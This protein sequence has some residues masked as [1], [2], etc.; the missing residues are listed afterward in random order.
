VALPPSRFVEELPGGVPALYRRALA[1]ADPELAAAVGRA[2]LDGKLR[3]FA[4]APGFLRRAWGPGWA[5]V[6]DA[7]YFKDP[8]TAHGMTDALRDAELLAR[9]IVAGT[10]EALAGYQAVRDEVSMG[11]F[12]ATDRIASFAWDLDEARTLHQALARHMAAEVELP[13]GLDRDAAAGTAAPP[14]A[15]EGG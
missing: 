14:R 1:D 3:P 10:D 4:G 5:L 6:G 9:A 12:E 2:R 7:G 11:L 8:L 13:L 15:A